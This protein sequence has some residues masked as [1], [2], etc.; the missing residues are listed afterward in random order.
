MSAIKATENT[1]GLKQFEKDKDVFQYQKHLE[2]T[3]S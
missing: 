2:S 1:K 3:G